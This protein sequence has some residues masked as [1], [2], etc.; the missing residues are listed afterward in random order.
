MI[1]EIK[2]CDEVRHVIHG[3][4]VGDDGRL[5]PSFRVRSR[6]TFDPAPRWRPKILLDGSSDLPNPMST[7]RSPRRSIR[8]LPGRSRPRSRRLIRPHLRKA[9][10]QTIEIGPVRSREAL[11]PRV[12]LDRARQGGRRPAPPLLPDLTSPYRVGFV[13]SSGPRRIAR[14]PGFSGGS[15]DGRS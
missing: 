13:S 5:P 15:S 12:A 10:D 6:A 2:R 7:S 11:D 14:E 9:L 4:V 3:E 1:T 8:P